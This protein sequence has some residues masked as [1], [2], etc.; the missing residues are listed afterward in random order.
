MSEQR[1]QRRLAAILAA[2]VVGYSRLMEQDE[3][4]TLAMLKARRKEVLEPLCT[5]FQGRVFK[6]T[7]DGVL[8]EFA[9]AVNA[10]ECAIELQRE[11][12]V[13][14][15]ELPDARRIVLRVGVNLGDVMS[16]GGDLYG[17][18]V[19][20]AARLERIAEPGSVVVSGSA[21]D[22]VKNKVT[23]RF[24]D[25]GP[26]TL[27]NI[28]QPVRAYRVADTPPVEIP[29]RRTAG[30]K[31][32][33]A[34]LP[35]VNMSDDPG[36]DYFAEGIA[37]DIIMDLSRFRS[38]LVISRPSSF[39][40]KGRS[41]SSQVIGQELGVQYIVEGSIRRA[42]SRVRVTAQL[43]DAETGNHLWGERYDR[44]VEDIFSV[45]DDVT[46]SIVANVA[47]RL[48]DVS[49]ERAHRKDLEQLS[50]YDVL[51]QGRYFLNRG[52]KDDILHAREL[53][54]R[55]L[56]MDPSNA[57]A[58]VGVAWSY[59]NEAGSDWTEDA[60]AAARRAFEMAIKA[61]DLDSWDSEAHL[62]LA[63][64][65]LRAQSNFDLAASRVENAIR[66]NPNDCN[67]YCFKSWLLTCAGDT[68]AGITCAQEALRRNPL[69]PNDCL[70]TVG[71]AEYLAGR[72]EQALS[73]F[74]QMSSSRHLDI[75]ALMAACYAE[76]GRT[77]DARTQAEEFR[78][79]IASELA[80]SPTQDAGTWRAYWARRTPLKDFAQLDRLLGSLRRAGLPN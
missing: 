46:Q 68:S 18:G 17:D 2:D 35:F 54:E 48:D 67:N 79:R 41:V 22:Y 37:E 78:R 6:V 47:S 64:G 15:S 21:Y 38:L 25:I 63:W 59:V 57:R 4:A 9:S 7:G 44:R 76:L 43:I 20:I 30:D 34:V 19:N 60:K 10:V 69:L 31:P 14:S 45:Q 55:V 5:R 77:N 28:T 49:S 13:A 65:H 36:Q 73:A 51:L 32:S 24:E 75:S 61:V 29:I 72:Y 39:A 52:S 8:V 42:E 16:E 80:V 12:A 74:G 66:L 71:F 3:A 58:H 56:E 1:T 40:Y 50:I 26:Q 23:A 70:H 53:Y 62:I 27:K 33:I 11:M